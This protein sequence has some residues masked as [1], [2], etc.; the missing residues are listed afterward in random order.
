MA[1]EVPEL[2]DEAKEKEESLYAKRQRKR[3]DA[4]FLHGVREII[5]YILFLVL[6]T[7]VIQT[8]AVELAYPMAS[9]MRDEVLGDA[10]EG[11]LAVDDIWG[12]LDGHFIDTTFLDE[13]DD[14]LVEEMPSGRWGYILDVNRIIGGIQFQQNRV[15]VG[16]ALPWNATPCQ[17]ARGLRRRASPPPPTSLPP[18]PHGPVAPPGGSKG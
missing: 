5:A 11:I 17:P 13:G 6:Y 2:D 12:Y 15:D 1:F 8:S 18:L 14:G 10:F 4:Q 3:D 9:K 16:G 7:I